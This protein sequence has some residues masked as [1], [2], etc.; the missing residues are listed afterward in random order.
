M[1]DPGQRA[2]NDGAEPQAIAFSLISQV[3]QNP[4]DSLSHH[5]VTVCGIALQTVVV[6]EGTYVALIDQTDVAAAIVA[7]ANPANPLGDG[8]GFIPQV[9]GALATLSSSLRLPV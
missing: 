3:R 9:A 8:T 7:N 4:I 2:K 5:C 1:L 6:M